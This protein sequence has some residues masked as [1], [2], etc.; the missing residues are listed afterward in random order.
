MST[1]KR[2]V[3]IEA[4]DKNKTYSGVKKFFCGNGVIDQYAHDN[5]KKDGQ[6]DNKIVGLLVEDLPIANKP[7]SVEHQLM[8]FY[9]MQN[10]SFPVDTVAREVLKQPEFYGYSLPKVVSTLKIFMIGIDKKYQKQPDRWGSMLLKAALIK[11]LEIAAVSTDIKAIVLDANPTAVEFYRKH[12]F[13]VL[14]DQPDEGGTIPMVLPIHQLKAAYARALQSEQ[15]SSTA[16]ST[17]AQE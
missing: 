14:Q 8:G 7:G 10:F 11:A 1:V 2:D 4:F 15:E 16:L 6:R 13:V 17:N 12:R 9:T 5:L 3:F